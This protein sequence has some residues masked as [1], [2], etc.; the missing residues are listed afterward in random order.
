MSATM[1]KVKGWIKTHIPQYGKEQHLMNYKP[2]HVLKRNRKIENRLREF[3]CEKDYSYINLN[4]LD[5]VE[6][7]E[8]IIINAQN[9]KEKW[10][11]FVD[12]KDLGK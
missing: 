11:I 10:L 3:G 4:I 8:K 12:N 2:Y 6:D 9:K 5:K 7:I 1:E